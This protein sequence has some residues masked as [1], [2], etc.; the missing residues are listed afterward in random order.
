MTLGPVESLELLQVPVTVRRQIGEDCKKK[1][2]GVFIREHI[3][4]QKWRAEKER[5]AE[6]KT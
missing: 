6:F 1:K 3:R 5:E 2:P 4:S